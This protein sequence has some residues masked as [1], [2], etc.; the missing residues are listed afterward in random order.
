MEWE[1]DR[2]IRREDQEKRG[3]Y[4][5]YDTGKALRD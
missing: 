2:V 5:S 4:V 1:S 3:D